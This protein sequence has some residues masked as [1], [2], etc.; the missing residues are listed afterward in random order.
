M[1]KVPFKSSAMTDLKVIQYDSSVTGRKIITYPFQ[2][3]FAGFDVELRKYLPHESSLGELRSVSQDG[4][5]YRT[6]EKLA[7]YLRMVSRPYEKVLGIFAL[8]MESEPVGAWLLRSFLLVNPPLGRIVEELIDFNNTMRVMECVLEGREGWRD[9]EKV[10]WFAKRVQL[11]SISKELVNSHRSDHE[12]PWR[13]WSEGVRLTLASPDEKWNEAVLERLKIELEARIL[14]I[15]KIIGR[16]DFDLHPRMFSSLVSQLVEAKSRLNAIDEGFV[17]FGRSDHVIA[18]KLGVVWEEIVEGLNESTIGKKILELI[19]KQKEKAHMPRDLSLG[20]ALLDALSEHP[21]LRRG[22]RKCDPISLLS[23][24]VENAGDGV[25]E[26]AFGSS[27]RMKAIEELL[28]LQ[29]FH[30]DDNLLTIRLDQVPYDIFVDED[31]LPREVKWT[32][33]KSSKGMSYKSLVLSYL[34]NDSFLVELLNNPKI[35]GKP[36]IVSLIALRCRSL[37]VLSVIASRRDLYSGFANRDVPIN[38]LMN[39][40]KIPLSTLRKF[41]HVRY[42]DK[43]VLQRLAKKGTQIRDEVRREIE[44][45]LRSLG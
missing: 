20:V 28:V 6:A 43:V 35:A 27:Y 42:I 12:T 38:L 17:R 21:L 25:V 32:E 22:S 18:S 11:I 39:P 2:P 26:V 23:L 37:K 4:S 30:L 45:Y 1:D 16:M 19:E 33:V 31:G 41:I 14:R 8:Y 40:A 29:G 3:E 36:G 15:A 44:R 34:D 24:F 7:D 10:K 5:I 13:D 9:D